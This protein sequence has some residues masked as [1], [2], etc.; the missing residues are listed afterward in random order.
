MKSCCGQTTAVPLRVLLVDDEPGDAVVMEAFLEMQEGLQCV[1]CASNGEDALKFLS[2]QDSPV[3][4]VLLDVY[5]PGMDG[6]DFLRE[7]Q[8]LPSPKP[9]VFVLSAYGA[10]GEEQIRHQVLRLGVA[11]YFEKGYPLDLICKRM[12]DL[13]ACRH[14]ETFASS[15]REGVL[16]ELAEELVDDLLPATKSVGRYYLMDALH[17]L[18]YT[19][20]RTWRICEVYDWIAEKNGVSCKSVDRAL[21]QTGK[22]M[23][24]H[25]AKRWQRMTAGMHLK[26]G[27]PSN[28]I[29]L[30]M[31]KKE[32]LY[33]ERH[34]VGRHGKAGHRYDA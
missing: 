34:L 16:E 5:M 19:A 6:I 29:L 24:H 33:R 1:G 7:W 31:L 32:V 30:E 26:E 14:T 2:R 25:S 12:R 21:R 27:A 18:T 10:F 20:R 17:Y 28:K 4:A 9:K 15:E 13:C 23:A 8:K 3:D 22:E 11:A